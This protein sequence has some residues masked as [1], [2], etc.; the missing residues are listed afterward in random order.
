MLRFYRQYLVASPKKQDKATLK[1]SLALRRHY[2]GTVCK[3]LQVELT[4]F[5]L[6]LAI[7]IFMRPANHY[8]GISLDGKAADLV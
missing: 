6:H 1:A 7:V 2:N 3:K 5:S 8:Q 4:T